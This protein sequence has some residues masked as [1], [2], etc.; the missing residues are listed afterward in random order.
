MADFLIKQHS[1]VPSL[2]G[3]LKDGDGNP[4]DL[5]AATSCVFHMRFEKT[6]AVV[7]E[8]GSC[9]FDGDRTTG[10]VTYIWADGDTDVVG[11]YFGEFEITW[12][13]DK[14]QTFPSTG[15]IVIEIIGDIA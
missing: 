12:T 13:G 14:E 8:D 15:Y 10:K 1:V 4:V 3:I 6:Q 7:I 11:T 2:T 5:S 9:V